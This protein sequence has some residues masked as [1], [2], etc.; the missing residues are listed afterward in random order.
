MPLYLYLVE[1]TDNWGYDDY[2]AFVCAAASEDD[3]RNM[4][5]EGLH[6]EWDRIF[7][8]WVHSSAKDT[9]K[10]TLIGRASRT[11][12]EP[13]VVLASYNAG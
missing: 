9:L 13:Q 5:P 8:P 6:A 10:V 11:T 4:R 12:K 3:A 2:D 7:D 1:R